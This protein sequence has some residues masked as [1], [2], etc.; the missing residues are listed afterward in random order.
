MRATLLASLATASAL[1]LP[2]PPAAAEGRPLRPADVFSLKDVADPRL[3]PDGRW[4]AYTLTTLDAKEDDSDTDVYLLSTD[5]GEPLRLTSS[6]RK[7]RAPASARTGSGSL[8]SRTARA[9][10]RRCTS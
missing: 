2:P 8:F 4:V 10:R 5:G 3:S 1:L 6:K 9:R 7:T